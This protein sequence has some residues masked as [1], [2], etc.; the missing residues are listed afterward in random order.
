MIDVVNQKAIIWRRPADEVGLEYE[1]A[2]IP[3]ELQG[4]LAAALR[5]LIDAVSNKDDAIAEMVIEEKPDHSSTVQGGHPPLDLQDRDGSCA[6][7]FGVQEKRR[8]VARGCR[9]RLPPSP[10]D[11]PPPKGIV[12]GSDQTVDVALR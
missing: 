12:P 7:R 4:A 11:V 8:A 5:E 1:V 2:E 3:A 10:L 9:G 6:V